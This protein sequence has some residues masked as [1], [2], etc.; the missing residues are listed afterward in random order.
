[1]CSN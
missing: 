1:M